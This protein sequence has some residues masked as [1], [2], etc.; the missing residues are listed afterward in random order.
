M[1][2]VW[3]DGTAV[4]STRLQ[5]QVNLDFVPVAYQQNRWWRVTRE[6][7]QDTLTARDE[8]QAK[9]V[10]ITAVSGVNFAKPT[11]VVRCVSFRLPL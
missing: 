8:G 9:G 6:V 3:T 2:G 11:Q 7:V 5:P 1:G 4:D 10:S